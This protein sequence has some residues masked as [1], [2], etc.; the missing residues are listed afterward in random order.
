MVIC[1]GPKLVLGYWKV[2]EGYNIIS[3]RKEIKI[4]DR[5]K[6]LKNSQSLRVSLMD[7]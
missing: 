4:V 6:G 2:C 5:G 3:T 1:R 7:T